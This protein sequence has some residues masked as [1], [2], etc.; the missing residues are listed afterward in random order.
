MGQVRVLSAGQMLRAALVVVL[1]FLAS[2]LLGLVR[3]AAYAASFGAAA[4]LDVFYA[5]QRIPELVFTL[6]AGGALG[7]AFI[8]VFNRYLGKDD[9]HAWRLASAVLSWS[10]LAAAGLGLVLAVTAPLYMPLLLSD[11]PQA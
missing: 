1:G 11:V 6:V 10:A 8:P 9:D 3:T 2:G 4:E 7:S 5:A